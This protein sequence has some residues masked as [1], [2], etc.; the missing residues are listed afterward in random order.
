M[1]N[2]GVDGTVEVQNAPQQE[3]VLPPQLRDHDGDETAGER[4][5]TDGDRV[6]QRDGGTD[7]DRDECV[8]LCSG[9]STPAPGRTGRSGTSWAAGS[10]RTEDRRERTSRQVTVLTRRLGRCVL[11]L[12]ELSW[13]DVAKTNSLSRCQSRP[14]ILDR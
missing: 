7:R 9:P 14:W 1:S 2:K 10:P 12:T 3:T 11:T 8:S 5:G 6:R 4:L 13:L